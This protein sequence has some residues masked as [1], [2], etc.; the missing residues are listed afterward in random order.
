MRVGDRDTRLGAEKNNRGREGVP[1][2]LL[3][4]AGRDGLV[5]PQPL[6]RLNVLAALLLLNLAFGLF[7]AASAEQS[8]SALASGPRA[9]PRDRTHPTMSPR[10]QPFSVRSVSTSRSRAATLSRSS[11]AVDSSAAS[12]CFF[13]MRN[14]AGDGRGAAGTGDGTATG[15]E[16]GKKK[17]FRGQRGQRQ[18]RDW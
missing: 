17:V 18:R 6:R 5:K 7:L 4:D 16:V 8:G 13:L 2:R 15:G 3:G 1:V 14:R 11:L 10:S 12:R 9:G